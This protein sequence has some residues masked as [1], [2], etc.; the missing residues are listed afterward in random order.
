MGLFYLLLF[1]HVDCLRLLWGGV[2]FVGHLESQRSY[3]DDSDF[4]DAVFDFR[5]YD[6]SRNFFQ[7]RDE[8]DKLYGGNCSRAW[9]N[10]GSGGT[11]NLWKIKIKKIASNSFA[12]HFERST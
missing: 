5:A 2:E 11:Q 10:D 7:P 9:C 6:F 1:E 8:L 4:H 3:H 12:S